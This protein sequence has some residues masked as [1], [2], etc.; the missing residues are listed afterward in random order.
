M[1][2]TSWHTRAT[3]DIYQGDEDGRWAAEP[4]YAVVFIPCDEDLLRLPHQGFKAWALH[5][6]EREHL[7]GV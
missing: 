5:L 4:P 7:G 6:W 1:T 3:A 2:A